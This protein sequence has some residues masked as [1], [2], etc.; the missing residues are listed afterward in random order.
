MNHR[1]TGWPRVNT[2]YLEGKEI[3]FALD[4]SQARVTDAA[5]KMGSGKRV[6]IPGHA[7]AASGGPLTNTVAFELY[8][9]FPDASPLPA[10]NIKQRR[11]ILHQFDR[12][13]ERNTEI[14]RLGHWRAKR[15]RMTCGRFTG[16]S[17]DWGKDDSSK[18]TQT[19]LIRTSWGRW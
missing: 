8:D 3:H 7:A 16:S 5:G 9:E 6:E 1:Q 2:L 19:S 14:Q 12:V 4:F 13:I 17:Y 11:E 18:L 15:N 10:R